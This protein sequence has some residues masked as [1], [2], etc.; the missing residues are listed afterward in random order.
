MQS[1]HIETAYQVYDYYMMDKQA[2]Y[3]MNILK[4]T[5]VKTNEKGI[6]ALNRHNDMAKEAEGFYIVFPGF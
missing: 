2:L 5:T 1:T 4:L 3:T 6:C